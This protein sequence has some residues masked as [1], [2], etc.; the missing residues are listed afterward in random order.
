MIPA[1]LR[2]LTLLPFAL[3]LIGCID[4]R[5]AQRAIEG[6]QQAEGGVIPDVMPAVRNESLPFHYP[7]AL[8]AV[9]AQGNVTLR[10]F[11]D[12]AGAVWPE[13]T[14]VVKSSGYPAFDSSAVAGS[15][16]LRFAPAMLHGR[17]MSISILLPVFFRH[18][19]GRPLPGDT[20][21][22]RNHTAP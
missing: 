7:P 5:T 6:V 1:S 15:R 2:A 10:I 20:I 8:Y 19:K 4:R 16:E 13:S 14:S 11:I 3:L 9:K 17:P 12:S 21:L 18:P 22:H